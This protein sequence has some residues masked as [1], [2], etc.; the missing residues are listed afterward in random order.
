MAYKRLIG[1]MKKVILLM[2]I[3]FSQLCY[4]Q[5]PLS[6]FGI[7]PNTTMKKFNSALVAK[8]Y[9]PYKTAE[10]RYGYKVKYAGYP[11]CEMD[12]KFNSGND[13]VLLV[14]IYF[15]HESIA[16]DETIFRSM[17]QQFKE[18]YGNEIDWNEGIMG[19]VNKTSKLKTYGKHKINMCSVAWYFND[20]EEEDGVH[21]Q[22]NTNA[23]PDN[24]VSV[25]SDI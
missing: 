12:V 6:V 22:Y 20:D 4:A 10:S 24:I 19:A 14:T 16:K 15:P 9:K 11:N 18:K 5:T 8:G 1:G 25:N 3:M 21:V 13:S 7:N 17:T 23:S 2:V